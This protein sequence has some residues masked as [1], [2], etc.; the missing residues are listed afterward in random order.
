M[1][2]FTMVMKPILSSVRILID[3]KSLASI[4]AHTTGSWSSSPDS[5][6]SWVNS[7][8]R[9]GDKSLARSM[10]RSSNANTLWKSLP[11][12][13]FTLGGT[14]EGVEVVLIGTI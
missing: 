10:R 11:P 1:S 4:S 3:S 13:V 5:A 8:M 7:A 12:G 2:F 14:E 9:A 6:I